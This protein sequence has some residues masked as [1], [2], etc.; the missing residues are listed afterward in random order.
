M[1]A[2][3]N[4]P[5]PSANQS[6]PAA[7]DA[8]PA[9][10]QSD[11]AAT[12]EPMVARAGTYYRNAR[13][14][15]FVIVVLMG[16]WFLY[17][18]FVKYPEE[19]RQYAA[20]SDQITAMENQRRVVEEQGR[21]FDNQAELDRLVFKRKNEMKEHPAFSIKVQEALGFALPPLGI[22]LMIYWLRKSRGEISL[23]D[24][25]LNSPGNPPVPIENI[26]ELD[27]A[28]WD[29][30]GIAYAY[31]T[32]PDGTTGNVRLDDF[33]YQAKP[34]REIVKQIEAELRSQDQTISGVKPKLPATSAK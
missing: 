1:T 10:Q 25:V 14:I 20:I 13:Y 29:R 19:N 22:G 26:D 18:G 31:Y 17:D 21:A 16:V 32:L 27:K 11:L 9:E 8:S 6:S 2:D 33:I 12:P 30:K 24:R 3:T 15:M 23:V 7:A 34:I 28:F 5:K 4:T